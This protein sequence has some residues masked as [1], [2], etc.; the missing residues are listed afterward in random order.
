MR[1]KQF[2]LAV[3]VFSV[4]ITVLWFG[5]HKRVQAQEQT[6]T[7]G[8]EV[9]C[10]HPDPYCGDAAYPSSLPAINTHESGDWYV[11]SESFGNQCGVKYCFPIGPFQCACGQPRS[12]RQCSSAERGAS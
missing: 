7:C 5:N 8:K 1:L 11:P 2:I 4:T 6:Y 3:L 10:G 9:R 12:V